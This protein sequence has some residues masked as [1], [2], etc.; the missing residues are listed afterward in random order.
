MNI[1]ENI[2]IRNDLESDL[3]GLLNI[4]KSA[5]TRYAEFLLA[6]QIP[7]LNETFDGVLEDFKEKSILAAAVKDRLAGASAPA[8]GE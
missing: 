5:S 2:L 1:E 4:Q 6:G 8:R 7:P 3:T